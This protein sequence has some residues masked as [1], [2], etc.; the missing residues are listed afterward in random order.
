MRIAPVRPHPVTPHRI[1][2][3]PNASGLLGEPQGKREGGMNM[4]PFALT[5]RLAP[6]LARAAH[7]AARFVE[8]P[9]ARRLRVVVAQGSVRARR[10]LLMHL[11]GI[12]NIQIVGIVGDA[13]SAIEVIEET[14]P[15]VILLDFLLSGGGGLFVLDS[16]GP[17]TEPGVIVTTANDCDEYREACAS[18]GATTVVSDHA[19]PGDLRGALAAVNA[20]RANASE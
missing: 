8:P 1:R 6:G 18:R 10:H 13:A 3:V 16:L 7:P 2:T 12:G 11:S 20:S 15:D 17:S 5:M 4:A 19:S 9:A 14:R